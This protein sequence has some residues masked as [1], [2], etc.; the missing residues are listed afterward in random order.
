MAD[1]SALM[2]RL[3]AD[4]KILHERC[5]LNGSLLDGWRGVMAAGCYW[6]VTSAQRGYAASV[7]VAV[8]FCRLVDRAKGVDATPLERV[9]PGAICWADEVGRQWLRFCEAEYGFSVQ[10]VDCPADSV[11]LTAGRGGAM[12]LETFQRGPHCLHIPGGQ[13]PACPAQA[14]AAQPQGDGAVGQGVVH[15]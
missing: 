9:F 12:L 5:P 15:D 14:G 6:W 7:D 10:S 1:L 4:L 8:D 11:L 3:H 13:A 2:S